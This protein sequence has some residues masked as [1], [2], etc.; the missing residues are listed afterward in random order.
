MEIILLPLFEVSLEL[1]A[2]SAK[3]SALTTATSAAHDAYH[4]LSVF[5]DLGRSLAVIYKC[6]NSTHTTT[7]PKRA[8]VLVRN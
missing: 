6:L 5:S 1:I 7:V 4:W 3:C 8:I 2:G